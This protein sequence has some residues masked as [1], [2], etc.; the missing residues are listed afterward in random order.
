MLDLV[1]VGAFDRF[2]AAET[3]LLATRR[4]GV[5]ADVASPRQVRSILLSCRGLNLNQTVKPSANFELASALA[6][7]LVASSNFFTTNT[8]LSGRL[9]VD[10]RGSTNAGLFFIFELTLKLAK[11]L[12]L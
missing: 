10:D 12:D 5:P 7:K 9:E 8:A 2:V 3:P 6:Q 11:P 4:D 1:R